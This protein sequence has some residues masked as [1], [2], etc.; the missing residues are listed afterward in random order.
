MPAVLCFLKRHSF[1]DARRPVGCRPPLCELL[2]DGTHGV[3]VAQWID[4]GFRFTLEAFDGP[5]RGVHLDTGNRALQLILGDRDEAAY[6][7]FAL[8]PA[9][10]R[11]A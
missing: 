6:P 5:V 3:P 4:T 1:R 7:G 2:R 9:E 11:G 10:W 8:A